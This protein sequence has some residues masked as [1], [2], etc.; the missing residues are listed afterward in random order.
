MK[1]PSRRSSVERRA[2]AGRAKRYVLK[3][4]R[5]NGSV[6]EPVTRHG[7]GQRGDERE[8]MRRRPQHHE[9]IE[10]VFE[11]PADVVARE[12][13][14]RGREDDD[15]VEAQADDALEA[16]ER[17]RRERR[18]RLSR[19]GRQEDG[20]RRERQRVHELRREDERDADGE[21]VDAL[22]V[23]LGMDAEGRTERRRRRRRVTY[24]VSAF[25]AR[26]QK[27]KNQKAKLIPAPTTQIR[28]KLLR[29]LFDAI[30]FAD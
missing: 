15:A 7:R 9:R 2:R 1:P 27:K 19:R 3:K 10:R 30:S 16:H 5:A 24:D 17:H 23:R 11:A 8:Q 13:K 14:L 20:L 25:G 4:R 28:V 29:I 12:E 22:R 21:L 18:A 6:W 26:Q